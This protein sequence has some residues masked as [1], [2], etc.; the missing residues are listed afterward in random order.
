MYIQKK[1]EKYHQKIQVPVVNLTSSCRCATS[2]FSPQNCS[3]MRAPSLLRGLCCHCRFHDFDNPI[4][5]QTLCKS[6]KAPTD[7][8]SNVG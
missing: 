7:E 1:H 6:S 8:R 4:N 3:I 5:Q 2:W